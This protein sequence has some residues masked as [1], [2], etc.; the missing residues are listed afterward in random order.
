MI[1]VILGG[2]GSGKTL[3]LIDMA[4]TSVSE[5]R[6]NIF[7]IDHNNRHMYDLKREIRLVNAAEFAIDTPEGFYGLLCGML[8]AN[9]D[10]T[11]IVVDGFLKII[12]S[13]IKPADLEGFFNK[14]DKLLNEHNVRMVIGIS[15]DPA[16][17]P[18][19]VTRYAI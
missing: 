1:Q 8:S 14:T 2:K 16:D 10:I 12:D 5:E 3:K 6:G 4:N 15:G 18:E 9:F 7:Y 11:L 17:M 19:F 13:A